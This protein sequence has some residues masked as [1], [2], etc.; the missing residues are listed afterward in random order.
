MLFLI[1]VSNWAIALCDPHNDSST[2]SFLEEN[3]PNVNCYYVCRDDYQSVLSGNISKIEID[4]C[5]GLIESGIVVDLGHADI[6]IYAV[7]DQKVIEARSFGF[8]GSDIS[9]F[10]A[11]MMQQNSRTIETTLRFS[12]DDMYMYNTKYFVANFIKENHCNIATDFKKVM[13]V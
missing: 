1:N 6:R 8:G 10:L 5:V 3:L 4:Q 13:K 7:Q 2:M 11:D 12:S 9:T